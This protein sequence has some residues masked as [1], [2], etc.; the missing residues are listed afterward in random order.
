M[1]HRALEIQGF[2]RK[3]DGFHRAG[4]DTEIGD[5]SRFDLGGEAGEED[6]GFP[7]CVH[8]RIHGIPE[9]SCKLEHLRFAVARKFEL[10]ETGDHD[11]L[12]IA[13][14]KHICITGLAEAHGEGEPC[15]R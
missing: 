3:V 12:L 13:E 15:V 4:I 11:R 7:R 6:L 10:V 9:E 2:S 14:D 5:A 1:F 8:T